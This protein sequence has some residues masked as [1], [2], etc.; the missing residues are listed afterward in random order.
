MK[1]RNISHE[2]HLK[3]AVVTSDQLGLGKAHLF[4][5]SAISIQNLLGL[6]MCAQCHVLKPIFHAYHDVLTV[7]G[8]CLC[9]GLNM[10]AARGPSN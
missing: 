9:F 5:S 3:P 4:P 7:L 6:F 10:A 2:L 1:G 8:K